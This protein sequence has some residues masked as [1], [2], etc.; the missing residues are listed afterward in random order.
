MFILME[1]REKGVYF[2]GGLERRE[3]GVYFDGEA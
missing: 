1:R 2:D 3:K